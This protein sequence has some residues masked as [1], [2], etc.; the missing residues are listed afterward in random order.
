M[1]STA[2]A[3]RGRGSVS[4]KKERDKNAQD[5]LKEIWDL[6]RGITNLRFEISKGREQHYGTRRDY[7]YDYD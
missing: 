6:R 3:T 2:E 7:D 1:V 4:G 5:L